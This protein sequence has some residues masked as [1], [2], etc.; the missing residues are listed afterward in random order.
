MDFTKA[1][2]A[3]EERQ[4]VHV[5]MEELAKAG[6]SAEN[7][8][9]LDKLIA[10]SKELKADI[11]RYEAIE[12]AEKEGRATT[13][14][15]EAAVGAG[16]DDEKRKAEEKKNQEE[17]A[18]KAFRAFMRVTEEVDQIP[19]EDRKLAMLSDVQRRDMNVASGAAGG[20]LV[21][22]IIQ[23]KIDIA[24]Q[25]IGPMLQVGTII[26]TDSGA[27]LSYPTSDDRS[28]M[29]E[30]VGENQQV[31]QQD[32]AVGTVQLTVYKYSTRM[33][34][35]SLELVQ[36]SVFNLDNFISDA[37]ALRL[38]RKL[39]LDFTVGTG[40]GQPR[41]IVTAVLATGAT[42]TAQGSAVND[43]GS[44]TGANSVG[45]RDL[46]SLVHAIDPLYRQGA[47]F[48]FADSTLLALGNELDKYGRPLWQTSLQVGAP[49]TV[50]GYPFYINPDMAAIDTGNA[51]VLFGQLSKYMIR[52]VKPLAT[53]RITERYIDF[54]QVAWL[55][56]ARYGGNL[57]D[58]GSHPVAALVQA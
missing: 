48:M 23:N 42:V 19:M 8:E 5:E 9:K 47:K 26:D 28:V 10:R 53:V 44:E 24:I 3:R 22:P 29:A 4:K 38:A 7:R 39:N 32:I 52:R 56:F 54:G 30:I 20:Y 43:G 13:R 11:E 25:T 45:F 41:G 15:P 35:A 34:K 51:T 40:T 31:S 14:P 2:E 50:L 46:L 21:P 1:R 58:A 6:I 17:R 57:V 27:P 16:Q 49:D 18:A 12:A 55:G 37:F 36:D 33:V